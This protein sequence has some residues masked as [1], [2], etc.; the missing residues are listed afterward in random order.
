MNITPSEKLTPKIEQSWLNVLQDEFQKPYFAEIK[1][2]LVEE[3]QKGIVIYPPGSLIFNAFNKT[4]FEKVKVVI[5]GQDPYHGPGQAHGLC[6]SVPNGIDP[7]PSLKNIFKELKAD[8]N[9][10]IPKSGNLE[11]WAEQGV[12]L[13][14]AMLTVRANEAAS[15]QKIGWQTFTDAVISILSDK[16]TGLVFL[17]WG[18]FAKTKAKLID[19]SKHNILQS[20]H[21][22]PLSERYFFGCKHFSKTNNLLIKQGLKPIDW[23]L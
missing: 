22:S 15:H 2:H 6:F 13:L 7:P 9:V 1:Q 18:A 23:S 20:G 4:P 10:Q 14:N 3:R 17:L 5:L 12:F 11:K 16:R 19:T 8:L 21:P